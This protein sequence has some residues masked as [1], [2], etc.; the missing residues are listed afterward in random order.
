MG[1]HILFCKLL[2]AH[3]LKNC[4]TKYCQYQLSY[5]PAIC[6]DSQSDLSNYVLII[7]LFSNLFFSPCFFHH[8]LNCHKAE[9][10]KSNHKHVLY[11]VNILQFLH[12][13][14]RSD[15]PEFSILD[16]KHQVDSENL[17][18]EYA[19]LYGIFFRLC[20]LLTMLLLYGIMSLDISAQPCAETVLES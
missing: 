7:I 8:V 3:I 1:F 15:K 13:H 5:M 18:I 11:L 6:S 16:L 12:Q 10:E 2:M 19:V 9:T 14:F 4:Q 20:L 17:I